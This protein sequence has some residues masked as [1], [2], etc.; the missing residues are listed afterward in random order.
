M[1]LSGFS[2]HLFLMPL[3]ETAVQ[4]SHPKLYIHPPARGDMPDQR[5]YL[6]RLY[7]TDSLMFKGGDLL[8]GKTMLMH[9][10][11]LVCLYDHRLMLSF[12]DTL[13]T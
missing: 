4:N 9:H 5:L 13:K 6:Y 8:D 2:S 7:S 3:C 12:L 10:I 1:G 11:H